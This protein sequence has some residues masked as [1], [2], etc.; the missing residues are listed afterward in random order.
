MFNWIKRVTRLEEASGLS[1][2]ELLVATAIMGILVVGA[3][4][5]HTTAYR[6]T[7]LNQDRAFCTQKAIQLINELREKTAGTDI[8]LS[9]LPFDQVIEDVSGVVLGQTFS[10][11]LSLQVNQDLTLFP[12]SPAAPISG[13]VKVGNHWKFQRQI[14]V[15]RFSYTQATNTEEPLLVTVRCFYTDASNPNK[16]GLPLAEITTV[17]R[18]LVQN[19]PTNQVFDLYVLAIENIPGWWVTHSALRP[20]I[21]DSLSKL[22][23]M[24]PGLGYRVHWITQN[25]LGRDKSYTPFIN[26]NPNITAGVYDPI[27]SVYYYPGLLQTTDNSSFWLFDPTF[28]N[29]GKIN[30]G[31]T[32]NGIGM[33]MTGASPPG[34]SITIPANSNQNFPGN[35]INNTTTRQILKSAGM[36]YDPMDLEPDDPIMAVRYALADYYNHAVRYPDELTEYCMRK[37]GS[38]PSRNANTK[39]WECIPNNPPPNL[40]ANFVQQYTEPSLEPSL[41]ILLEQLYQNPAAYQNS[42]ILNAHGQVL[43]I[44]PLRNYS[45]PAKFPPD[46]PGVRVVTHPEQLE[47]QNGSNIK[48]RVYSFLSYIDSTWTTSNCN[49]VQNPTYGPTAILSKDCNPLNISPDPANLDNEVPIVIRITGKDFTGY[50]LSNISVQRILGNPTTGYS[51]DLA[52]TS[53]PAS[54]D[55]NKMWYSP[56]YHLNPLGGN[57]LILL[58]YNTPLRHGLAPDN[59]GLPDARRLDLYGMEYLPAP[60]GSDFSSNLASTRD[61]DFKNTA[62]WIITLD[63]TSGRLN[64]LQLTIETRIGLYRNP[65]EPDSSY[66]DRLLSPGYDPA[67]P[68]V[69]MPDAPQTSNSIYLWG[70][71]YKFVTARGIPSN[72]SRTYTWVSDLTCDSAGADPYPCKDPAGD[73]SPS[74]PYRAGPSGMQGRDFPTTT[75]PNTGNPYRAPFTERFQFMGDPLHNPYLDVKLDQRYNWYF[76]SINTSNG[77]SGFIN[78]ANGW[79]GRVPLDYPRFSQIYRMGVLRSRSI[80]SNFTGRPSYYLNPGGVVGADGD[81]PSVYPLT[82]KNWIRIPKTGFVDR[83]GDGN[84]T[85]NNPS[86]INLDEMVGGK[87]GR[88]RTV[89]QFDANPPTGAAWYAKTWLGEL[90]PDLLPGG[91]NY[92][93]LNDIGWRDRGNLPTINSSVI[94]KMDTEKQTYLGYNASLA[95]QDEGPPSFFNNDTPYNHVSS[96]GSFYQTCQGLNMAN[97]FNF[98]LNNRIFTDLPFKP[99]QNIGNPPESGIMPYNTSLMQTKISLFSPFYYHDSNTTCTTVNFPNHLGSALLQVQ[100]N[101]N[102]SAQPDADDQFGYFLMNGLAPSGDPDPNLAANPNDFLA[103]FNVMALTYGFMLAGQ[104]V[105][106]ITKA[107]LPLSPQN[108]PYGSIRQLPRVEVVRPDPTDVQALTN[109]TTLTIAWRI[110]WRRWDGQPYTLDYNPSTFYETTP[111]YYIPMYSADGVEWR[112]IIG[113]NDVVPIPADKWPGRAALP[114]QDGGNY[115]PVLDPISKKH[116]LCRGAGT[117]DCPGT[118]D[119]PLTLEQYVWNVAALNPPLNLGASNNPPGQVYTIRV[120]VYRKNIYNHFAYHDLQIRI[121]P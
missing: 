89:R 75:L 7:T 15:R 117:N 35:P 2:I 111:L 8:S 72:V 86:Y 39:L 54:P 88:T 90:Y 107:L 70:S 63:N 11:T 34:A 26:T 87:G 115:D 103:R 121:T 25:A 36:L 100:L 61:T 69:Y 47:Y 6:S 93:T 51:I 73:G 1:L 84:D 67:N 42:L 116:Y 82:E 106:P 41:R 66:I 43:P 16:G 113:D 52:P 45:D 5:Y 109:P 96:G 3:I 108:I 95:T 13:N 44:P 31:L 14:D 120:V 81:W 112:Y 79:S 98:S 102:A 80:Y 119:N 91:A 22:Q 40:P 57:D 53:K 78:T 38:L 46:F 27:D 99:D 12:D 21:T 28:L 97:A 33:P 77:L 4:T 71:I 59:T 24:N 118:I 29:K 105:H 58:L 20:I 104:P 18:G 9:L 65:G 94:F 50:S 56:S 62:R 64:D 92:Y 55:H 30:P 85:S 23:A 49:N 60:V 10:P 110:T 32:T 68:Y 48:L 114:K 17:M 101:P 74:Q 76:R 83:P 37:F 19:T